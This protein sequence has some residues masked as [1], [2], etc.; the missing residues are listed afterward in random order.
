MR[1]IQLDA[2]LYTLD[3]MSC[4]ATRSRVGRARRRLLP[5]ARQIRWWRGA[6]TVAV[7]VSAPLIPLW[8][9]SLYPTD[10]PPP[11][12]LLPILHYLPSSPI[13]LLSLSFVGSTSRNPPLHNHNDTGNP[14]HHAPPQGIGAQR[15]LGDR[16]EQASQTSQEGINTT[17]QSSTNCF[18]P[19]RSRASCGA[20]AASHSVGRANTHT[21]ACNAGPVEAAGERSLP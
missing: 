20:T 14:S 10:S 7:W 12:L 2:G 13:H 11:S 19:P 15:N 9:S 5:F 21:N 8:S 1:P 16:L 6:R 4:M 17:Y 3:A 18:H